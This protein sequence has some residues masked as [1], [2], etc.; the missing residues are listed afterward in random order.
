MNQTGQGT[1]CLV[2]LLHGL[3]MVQIQPEWYRDRKYHAPLSA[4]VS[5]NV[6]IVMFTCLLFARTV[7]P[8][9]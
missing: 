4:Q 1:F 3:R 2:N 6:G 8:C 9:G 7:G 5:R